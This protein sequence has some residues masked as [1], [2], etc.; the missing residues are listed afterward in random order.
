[1]AT[2]SQPSR[3]EPPGA[4]KIG[5]A[6]VL[7]LVMIVVSSTTA[8]YTGYLLWKGDPGTEV[9]NTLPAGCAWVA[10]AQDTDELDAALADVARWHALPSQ[11]TATVR[12]LAAETR[13]TLRAAAPAIDA[14][15]GVGLCRW[16][17]GW[18]VT[19]GL[20]PGNDDAV[21]QLQ[22]VVAGHVGLSD[23][24]W[25]TGDSVGGYIEYALSP[26][27]GAPRAAMLQG[28]KRLVIAV[29]AEPL[30]PPTPKA[31]QAAPPP[32]ADA[33]A[34]LTRVVKATKA[35]PMRE[36]I[37]VR[38]A[39]ERV[40]SGA[41]Q[42]GAA[43]AALQRWAKPF[44]DAFPMPLFHP[45]ATY[46]GLSVRRDASDQRTHVHMHVGESQ[47]G[48][49]LLKRTLDPQ[50]T[51]SASAHIDQ[52]VDAAGVVRFA[53]GG[54]PQLGPLLSRFTPVA[55]LV[56]ALGADQAN[57]AHRVGA[58]LTGQAVWQRKGE[59]WRLS[60][61]LAAG[62]D[63]AAKAFVS[64][65]ADASNASDVAF[66][67]VPGWLVVAPSD[68][69]RAASAFT[70]SKGYSSAR[71]AGDLATERPRVL[72][73]NQGFFVTAGHTLPGVIAGPAQLETLWLDT[74]LILHL[75]F[76]TPR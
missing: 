19:V 46:V 65:R 3:P 27:G 38:S 68:A 59:V 70:Q 23:R 48:V 73:N 32:A 14:A 2:E 57:T 67:H 52:D 1:M 36:D 69:A 49:A 12:T 55:P 58:L 25:H 22:R 75:S 9:L 35:K 43:P 45:H 17:D 5:L 28:A 63:A 39:M 41:L 4:Q 40:G 44:G 60:L 37:T 13:A 30:A 18:V 74:G 64:A 21:T 15:A 47:R 7:G 11:V 33:S 24:T 29:P 6:V 16:H 31:A 66:A 72:D 53:P 62:K 61:Q 20:R 8:I 42:L 71:L 51:L 54:L 26:E 34:L 10:L 76:P 50:G 56:R